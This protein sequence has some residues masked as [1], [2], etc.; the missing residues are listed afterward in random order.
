MYVSPSGHHVPEYAIAGKMT[1]LYCWSAAARYVAAFA[2]CAP[3][4][5]ARPASATEFHTLFMSSW[6]T[7]TGGLARYQSPQPTMVVS[8]LVF[9]GASRAGSH[10]SRTTASCSIVRPWLLIELCGS[11]WPGVSLAPAAASAVMAA[12]HCV[13]SPDTTYA[14][15]YAHAG[16][17][18]PGL[19]S[20]D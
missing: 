5:S 1:L 6:K 12:V 16:H 20:A 7:S 2:S 4:F 8:R 18:P 14:A 13:A 15:A 19:A 3:P 9:V 17:P 11:G 10:Q